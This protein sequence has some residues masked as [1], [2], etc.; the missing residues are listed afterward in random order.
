MFLEFKINEGYKRSSSTTFLKRF[1]TL[2]LWGVT[3]D[4]GRALLV[5]LACLSNLMLSGKV[6]IPSRVSCTG[7]TYAR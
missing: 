5:K 7:P 1:R 6:P 4:S 3:G 2:N